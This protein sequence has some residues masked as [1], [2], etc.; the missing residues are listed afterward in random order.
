MVNVPAVGSGAVSH[1]EAQVSLPLDVK[2]R[3]PPGANSSHCGA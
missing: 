2:T 3:A 1:V